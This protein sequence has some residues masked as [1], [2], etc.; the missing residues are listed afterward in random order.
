MGSRGIGGKGIGRKGIGRKGIDSKRIIVIR[1]QKE[2]A[3][4]GEDSRENFL[5]NKR[6][7]SYRTFWRRF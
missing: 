4:L 7:L 5:E 3:R 1:E 6:E 2:R